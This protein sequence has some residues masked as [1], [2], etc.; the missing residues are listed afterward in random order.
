MFWKPVT[1]LFFNPTSN[2]DI[3]NFRQHMQVTKAEGLT[4]QVY[5]P[6]KCTALQG[7]T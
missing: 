5:E 2:R 4:P 7:W 1:K 3:L 6:F